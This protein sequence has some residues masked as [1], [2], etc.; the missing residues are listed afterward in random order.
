[1]MKRVASMV[2]MASAILSPAAAI[3]DPALG[4]RLG[5]DLDRQ[6][7]SEK[8]SEK[9]ARVLVTC[10]VASHIASARALLSATDKRT[11][12][13]ASDAL[14]VDRCDKLDTNETASVGGFQYPADILR[15]MIAETF[16]A[17]SLDRAA[18]LPNLPV[19]RAY[20]RS[21]F[22]LSGRNSAV[23]SMAVC[24]AENAPNG[25]SALLRTE[26]YSPIEMA[27]VKAL[28]PTMG[29][30]LQLG[31]NLHAN[32]QTLRAAIA[33]GLYHRMMDPVAPVPAA[34]GK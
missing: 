21:W 4:S 13:K 33:E 10:M 3:A 7:H 18:K 16:L 17:G 32:R 26:A 22:A 9:Q 19:K 2:A 20:S 24:L 8:A 5:P 15:G 28:G 31:V 11:K 14:D 1:M 34:A 29:K 25:V 6:Y 12:E 23:D 30:C 27:A